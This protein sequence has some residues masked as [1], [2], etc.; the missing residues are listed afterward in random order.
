MTHKKRLD[1]LKKRLTKGTDFKEIYTYF[2]DHLGENDKFLSNG[3]RI[4]HELLE[5]TLTRVAEE[6][7]QKAVVFTD[8][9]A[10]RVRNEPFVHGSCMMAA[11]LLTYFYFEDIATGMAAVTG[12]SQPGKTY[13][14]RFSTELRRPPPKPSTN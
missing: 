9:L 13:C 1:E 6:L 10:I 14:I 12:L 3:E 7:L 2:F 5:A 11:H 4:G 8:F